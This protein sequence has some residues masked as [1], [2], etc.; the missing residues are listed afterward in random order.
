MA[1]AAAKLSP[2]P[3]VSFTSTCTARNPAAQP[4]EVRTSA[5]G[6]MHSR[7]GTSTTT[8]TGPAAGRLLQGRHGS[9]RTIQHQ[10]HSILR[11]TGH[12]GV[13]ITRPP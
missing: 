8:T 7:D 11:A 4:L 9:S 10:A 3:T 6:H 13:Q 12:A 5:G 1:M 2:Q